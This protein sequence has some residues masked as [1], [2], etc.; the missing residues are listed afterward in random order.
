MAS[1]SPWPALLGWY[2]CGLLAAAQLGK[3]SA[4]APWI[5]PALGLGL[6]LMAVVISALEAGGALLGSAG[7]RLAGR[8]GLE[9]TLAI[10]L[11]ALAAAGGLQALASGGATLLAARALEALG[12][13]GVIVTAPVLMARHAA[14]GGGPHT[15]AQAMSLWS[16]FVPMGIACGAAIAAALAA[17]GGWRIALA[18]LA[19]PAAFAALRVWRGG[20]ADRPDRAVP[21][22]AGSATGTGTGQ[23]G[24]PARAAQTAPSAPTAPTAR[25]AQTAQTG[26]RG[27]APA[28]GAD[29]DSS[30]DPGASAKASAAPARQRARRA[31]RCL[32]WAFGGFAL[33]QVG[34]IALLPSWL[35][36]VG[37]LGAGQAG[38]WTALV[39]TTAVA[40][41]LPAS[42]L[43]RR[44]GPP[45][46]P[47]LV[48]QLLSALLLWGVF[49][50]LPGTAPQA[51]GL[52]APAPVLRAV[53]LAGLVN[54]LGGVVAA[55]CFALLPR[56]ASLPVEPAASAAPVSPVPPVPPVAAD[57]AAGTA[58][59]HAARR[60]V[61]DPALLVQANGWL[62]QCG[63]SGSLAGPP[64]MA[65][66][67]ER[68][69]WGAAAWVGAAVS[70]AMLPLLWRATA[71]VVA[72]DRTPAAPAQASA[73]ASG[74]KA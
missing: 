44:A 61:P 72:G 50:D 6:T 20:Q 46:A 25:T 74:P 31:L 21:A 3:M 52:A 34:M 42:L 41:S 38:A 57:T 39:A 47:L 10:G 19:V 59:G 23:D 40:G 65:A 16:T 70:L 8:W 17:H 73:A 51:T 5:G 63:A 33:F 53:V 55:L 2:G 68:G 62:A 4:L 69:G 48:A 11:A 67:V 54:A 49:A 71:A 60:A 35:V 66:A 1:R 36:Q 27:D 13:L 43:L 26:S 30:T 22:T 24:A 28:L 64:L 12:Y 37:G 9:R 45:R 56:W 15:V 29:T 58:P 18:V 32:A 7:G 14:H